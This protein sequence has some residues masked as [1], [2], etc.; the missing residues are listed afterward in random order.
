VHK[1]WFFKQTKETEF[2]GY[3]SEIKNMTA[4][5]LGQQA[6]DLHKFKPETTLE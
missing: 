4:Q 5:S 1:L 2:S 6:Q 3:N